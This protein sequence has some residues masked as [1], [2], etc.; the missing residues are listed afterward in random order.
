M[1]S[2]FPNLVLGFDKRCKEFRK[3]A[4]VRVLARQTLSLLWLHR[5]IPWHGNVAN[6][7]FVGLRLSTSSNWGRQGAPGVIGIAHSMPEVS[8]WQSGWQ[9]DGVS[10]DGGVLEG[11]RVITRVVCVPHA[12]N[13]RGCYHEWGH[14]LD[15]CDVV[16]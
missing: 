11:S 12:W 9:V 14:L 5:V 2:T 8:L 7:H 3:N 4:G 6:P 16:L 15:V 1:K 13:G 10:S